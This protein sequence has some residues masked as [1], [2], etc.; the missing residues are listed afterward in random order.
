MQGLNHIIYMRTSL[1]AF[2]IKTNFSLNIKSGITVLMH[3]TQ[4][5]K[6]YKN[7]NNYD[8]HN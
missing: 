2:S 5:V 3:C 7:G 1:C 4:T 6:L 8:S